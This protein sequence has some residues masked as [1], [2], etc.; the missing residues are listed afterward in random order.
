MVV[1]ALL[2][3]AVF[4]YY[5]IIQSFIYTFFDLDFTTN[6]LKAEF[7]WFENYAD[8]M[9]S[10]QFWY[11]FGFTVGFTAAV[12]VVDLT[13]GML[14]ALATFYVNKPLRGILRAI[15][16]VPWAI[17]KVIQA[18]MWRWMLNADVGPIGDLL[19]RI[20][21]TEAPPLFLV[22]QVLAMG[23]V[24]LAYT[25]KGASISAF[26]LMGGLALIPREVHES[27]IVD[28]ARSTRRF[29]S[30][31][32]PMVLPTVFVALL[33]RSRDA[34][35]VFDVI[36]GLTGGG[37]GTTTD[38]LSTFAYNA[39]FRYAQFGRASTY[40]VVTFILVAVVGVIYI[41]RIRKNFRFRE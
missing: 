3:L 19:V 39:Y 36:Y 27:A 4:N 41:Q 12:T 6:W 15:I 20:G 8:V 11:T 18:A 31:T 32:L 10:S 14:L 2:G 21:I 5:P 13:L 30:I 38:T 7:I 25:W 40:A 29:F 34:L 28:G 16:I 17:P 26:F 33:Y 37:P 22:N 9:R 23:S 35:R 1:P 24:V